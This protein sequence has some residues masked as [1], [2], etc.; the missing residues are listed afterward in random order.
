[1][2]YAILVIPLLVEGGVDRSRTVRVLVVDC[3]EA[4]QVE[5][6]VRRSGLSEAEARAIIAAQATRERRL[7]AAD[8]VIDNGGAP[9]ALSAQVSRLHEKYLT[10]A[11]PRTAS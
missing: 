5:R 8:D 4:L 6:V 2:P 3:P 7:A 10:L 9:E 1:G 11:R